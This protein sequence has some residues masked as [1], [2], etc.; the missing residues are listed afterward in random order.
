VAPGVTS[1]FLANREKV[2]ARSAKAVA[3][4]IKSANVVETADEDNRD[5]E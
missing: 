3:P 5:E 4:K 2:I 1:T